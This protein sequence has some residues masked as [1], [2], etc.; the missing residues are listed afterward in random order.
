[1]FQRFSSFFNVSFIV[2]LQ[3][4]EPFVRV[5]QLCPNPGR[6]DGFIQNLEDHSVIMICFCFFM[7]IGESLKFKKL[8]QL[9]LSSLCDCV[10]DCFLVRVN[11][12]KC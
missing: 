3:V 8:E 2:W 4:L 12:T 1:M 5:M 9:F 7:A 10:N 11:W 6:P